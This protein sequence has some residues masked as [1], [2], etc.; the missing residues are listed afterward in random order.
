MRPGICGYGAC[1]Q[2]SC[3]VHWSECLG[4]SWPVSR[5]RAGNVKHGPCALGMEGNPGI[6]V[7]A[8]SSPAAAV[9]GSVGWKHLFAKVPPGRCSRI[10]HWGNFLARGCQ[11]HLCRAAMGSLFV[12]NLSSSLEHPS[13]R[14]MTGWTVLRLLGCNAWRLLIARQ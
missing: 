4:E 14:V 8:P 5:L 7:T 9:H 12:G 2:G 11:R 10:R 1:C 6:I 13:P 3:C